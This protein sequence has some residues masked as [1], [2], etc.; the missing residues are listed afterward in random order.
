MLGRVFLCGGGLKGF[1]GRNIEEVAPDNGTESEG[2]RKIS[3]GVRWM[4]SSF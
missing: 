4:S 1:L 3:C 2:L